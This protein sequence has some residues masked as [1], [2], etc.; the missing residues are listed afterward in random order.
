M[1]TPDPFKILVVDDEEIVRCAVEMF[2]DHLGYSAVCVKDGL[3]GISELQKS[4]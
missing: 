4:G 1:E 2:F 3:A